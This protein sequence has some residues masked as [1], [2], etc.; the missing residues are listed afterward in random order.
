MQLKKEKAKQAKKR[1]DFLLKQSDIFS[2]FGKVQGADPAGTSS[3]PTQTTT[4]TTSSASL[5]GPPSPSRRRA[6]VD[7]SASKSADPASAQEEDPDDAPAPVYLTSQPTTLGGYD[8][9][10]KMRPY[11]LEGL[12]WMVR[13]QEHGVNGI[14][15]DE[16]GLGKTLQSISVLVYMKEYMDVGGPH[17]IVVPKSTLSN[18]MNELRRW[19]PT[20][21]PLKFHGVKVRVCWGGVLEHEAGD[22]PT[23][24]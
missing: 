1:L 16:M 21:R 14:L 11:Q 4:T 6:S 5:S 23:R 15:A 24:V 3:A 10:S 2:H 13:L 17:I 20:L 8:K 19:A 22:P 18:W 9:N 7:D 12:N